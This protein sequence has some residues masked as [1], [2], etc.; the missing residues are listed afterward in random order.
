MSVLSF[1]DII[2]HRLGFPPQ[3]QHILV[4]NKSLSGIDSLKDYVTEDDD[5][6]SMVLLYQTEADVELSRKYVRFSRHLVE[7]IHRTKRSD[8]M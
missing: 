6:T 7:R 4:N 8:V 3:E 5:A 1:K 2:H